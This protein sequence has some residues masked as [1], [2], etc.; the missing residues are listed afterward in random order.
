M[1]ALSKEIPLFGML[2]LESRN[3]WNQVS[4]NLSR[5][6]TKVS[7]KHGTSGSLGM[8]GYVSSVIDCRKGWHGYLNHG[9]CR[10]SSRYRFGL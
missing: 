7:T 4:I 1:E 3:S 8:S 5:S 9:A 10:C 2:S 6:D